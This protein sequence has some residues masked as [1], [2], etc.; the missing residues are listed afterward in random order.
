LEPL[1]C[2]RLAGSRQ[3]HRQKEAVCLRKL[4]PALSTPEALFRKHITGQNDF[5]FSFE[6]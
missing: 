6:A 2:A 4:G 1:R 3:A 5:R